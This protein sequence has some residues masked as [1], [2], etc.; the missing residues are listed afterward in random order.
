MKVVKR[1]TSKKQNK[2]KRKKRGWDVVVVSRVD[3]SSSMTN[4]SEIVFPC[5]VG[6]MVCR[7]CSAFSAL[8]FGCLGPSSGLDCLFAQ[9]FRIA[10]KSLSFWLLTSVC[11]PSSVIDRCKNRR[12]C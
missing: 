6:D 10:A 4:G 11:W 7:R 3:Q 5:P 1:K 8:T 12:E 9:T 2:G